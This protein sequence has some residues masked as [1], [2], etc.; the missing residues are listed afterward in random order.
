MW[1]KPVAKTLRE[2]CH[3]GQTAA[4]HVTGE[5]LVHNPS[6][7]A[8]GPTVYVMTPYNN[9]R[10]VSNVYDEKNKEVLSITLQTK[11]QVK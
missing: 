3:P 4:N 7:D 2:R 1:T 5:T 9:L 8:A 10:S 11:I 6:T